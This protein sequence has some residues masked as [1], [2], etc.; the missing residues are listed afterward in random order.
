MLRALSVFF[1]LTSLRNPA[2]HQAL[3]EQ[4]EKAAHC[5]ISLQLSTPSSKP[6]VR[7]LICVEALFGAHGT[8]SD[9]F[10]LFYL[11]NEGQI[12]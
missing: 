7:R 8:L 9:S 3:C 4:R 11:P 10:T 12:S 1:R 5:R 2:L 6:F